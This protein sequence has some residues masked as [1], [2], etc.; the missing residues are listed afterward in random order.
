MSLHDTRAQQSESTWFTGISPV[1][2]I[3]I[4]FLLLFT[5]SCG[6]GVTSADVAGQVGNPV[7]TSLPASPSLDSFKTEVTSGCH[8]QDSS[9]KC[10]AL[11]YVV[12]DDSNGSPAVAQSSVVAGVATINR[13]WSQ[14]QI[15]FQIDQL[16]L[17]DPEKYHL[18][19]HSAENAELDEIRKTFMDQSSLLVVTTGK[20]DRSGS[21]GSTG[22]NAWTSMPGEGFY[23]AILEGPVGD[24]PNII[25]HEL[26]HYLN[27]DHVTNTDYLMNPVIYNQ[28][29]QL[30]RSECR[31]AVNAVDD[32]WKAMTR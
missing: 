13:I 5:G 2:F 4:M 11:K 19:F 18:S 20:W 6:P 25:A 30:S 21:L 22:A 1:S 10:L 27:L 12:F 9:Q 29:K 32:Y 31:L 26:G 15:Q 28:S 23:G 16:L 17:V 3:R 8:R 14:C 24:Y 7:Q